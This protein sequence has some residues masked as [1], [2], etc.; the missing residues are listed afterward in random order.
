MFEMSPAPWEEEA[1][2]LWFDDYGAYPPNELVH[3]LVVRAKL[4][5][6]AAAGRALVT[7]GNLPLAC[8]P[9][10]TRYFAD[11]LKGRWTSRHTDALGMASLWLG[12]EQLEWVEA[13]AQAV[14]AGSASM[15]RLRHVAV[16]LAEIPQARR[17]E[18]LFDVG[19][20][21]VDPQT[22]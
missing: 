4:L 17:D 7:V 22:S 10:I 13:F 1:L 16:L 6:I 12:T 9:G 14:G 11:K 20:E 18:W 5:G 21:L 19:A 2:H 15:A 3:P 8:I